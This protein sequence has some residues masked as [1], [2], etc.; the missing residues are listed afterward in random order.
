MAGFERVPVIALT[1][2]A[3]DTDRAQALAAGCVGYLSK[4][5]EIGE[6]ISTIRR[7]LAG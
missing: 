6:V 1:A 3:S 5:A 2:K 4:P 7:S